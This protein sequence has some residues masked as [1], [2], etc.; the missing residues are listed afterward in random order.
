MLAPST[1]CPPF[2]K[3]PKILGDL[4]TIR[5]Y[6]TP[7]EVFSNPQWNDRHRADKFSAFL[8]LCHDVI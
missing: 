8:S 3:T 7:D 4:L 6:L 2:W 5:N 1:F